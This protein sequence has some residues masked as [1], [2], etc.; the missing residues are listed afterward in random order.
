MARCV[1]QSNHWHHPTFLWAIQVI[2]GSQVRGFS[3]LNVYHARV[4]LTFNI[5][6]RLGGNKIHGEIAKELCDN[7]GLNDP[8]AGDKY[9]CDHIV[10]ML[11]WVRLYPNFSFYTQMPVNSFNPALSVGNYFGCG[12]CNKPLRL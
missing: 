9:G 5:S 11:S 7:K 12:I 8:P 3:I 1:W 4:F 10:S 6:Y 2:K